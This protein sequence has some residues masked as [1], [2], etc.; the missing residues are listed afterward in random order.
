MMALLEELKPPAGP[1][2]FRLVGLRGCVSFISYPPSETDS[3]ENLPS[4]L[5]SRIVA[6]VGKAQHDFFD[7][8]WPL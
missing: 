1:L 5:A 2:F 6:K 7:I 4:R 3:E 8:G